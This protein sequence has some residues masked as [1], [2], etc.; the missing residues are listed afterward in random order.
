MKPMRFEGFFAG[1]MLMFLCGK[2]G[3]C[4]APPREEAPKTAPTGSVGE[5]D[6]RGP[7]DQTVL[8]VRGQANRIRIAP[9]QNGAT[10]EG[11]AKV[12]NTLKSQ[13]VAIEETVWL[14]D[15]LDLYIDWLAEC[16]RKIP[17][18]VTP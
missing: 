11:V 8:A 14:C 17:S 2:I 18:G 7:Q 9:I 15:Q 1:V 6:D 4:V 10:H 3:S 5:A 13:A 12:R 16:Q